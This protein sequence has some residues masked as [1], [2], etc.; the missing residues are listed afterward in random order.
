MGTSCL[1]M[2]WLAARMT[3]PGPTAV[4]APISMRPASAPTCTQ[5][6]RATSWSSTSVPSVAVT[7]Q[8]RPS[9]T[10]SPSRICRQPARVSPVPKRTEPQ[11]A[12]SQRQAS[13]RKASPTGVGTQANRAIHSSS[14]AAAR[15]CF[16]PGG[17]VC[18]AAAGDMDAEQSDGA[19]PDR[20]GAL[21]P[22]SD[23][24]GSDWP[25]AV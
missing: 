16:A 15:R 25:G 7:K 23:W 14:M 8:P 18:P 20:P 9:R 5:G 13:S 3:V 11:R 21:S 22:G 24:P 4:C 12:N 19:G 17:P 6:D 2:R 1:A 10:L